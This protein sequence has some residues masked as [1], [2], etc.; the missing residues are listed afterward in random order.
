M[1]RQIA[2]GCSMGQSRLV[3]NSPAGAEH[4][5]AE[6]GALRPD[7]IRRE[8]GK[9][10]ASAVFRDSLRLISFLRFVVEA[11]LTGQTSQ[12]KAYTVAI[13][14]F[15]RPASF[16]PQDDPIVRVEAG[17]LRRALA[18]YYES[19]GLDD[20]IV[21]ELLRG[22][23][24]PL[25]RRRAFG[26]SSGPPL[27]RAPSD[28]ADDGIAA[29]FQALSDDQATL[30]AIFERLMEVRRQIEAMAAEAELAKTL[31]ERSDLARRRR[32]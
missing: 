27:H 18:H 8:L 15:E 10:V 2:E 4:C 28:F 22:S 12:I 29:A 31:L 11:V 3:T 32:D 24:V 5:H 16:N 19:A 17:R 21:I 9:I 26:P 1:A 25:F 23:Y 20:P 7:E 6:P 13:E 30:R 14:A